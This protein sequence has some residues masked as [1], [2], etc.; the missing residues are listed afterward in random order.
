MQEGMINALSL[1]RSLAPLNAQRLNESSSHDYWTAI[2]AERSTKMNLGV[3]N[4]V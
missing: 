2:S 4:D 1:H 3:D